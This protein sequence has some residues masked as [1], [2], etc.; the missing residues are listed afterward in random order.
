MKGFRKLQPTAQDVHAD[1]VLTNIS[2]SYAQSQDAF[3]ATKVFPIIPVDKQSDRYVVYTKNDWFRDEARKR[4]DNQESAGSGYNLSRDSYQA[5]VWAIHKDVGR[6]SRLNADSGIDLDDGATRF[7]TN[8]ILLRQEI[9]FV[10]D[11][12]TTGVWGT[13]ATPAATWDDYTGSDPIEDIE[14]AKESILSVTG[15]MP[16]TLVI[17]YQAFRKLKHHPDLVARIQFS[18]DKVL[19]PQLVARFLELDNVYV[20]RAIKA[21]NV[22]GETAAYAFVHGKHAWVG[23]VNPSP[24]PFE[25][26]AGYTFSWNGFNALGSAIA[27]DKFEI[28]RTKTTRYEAESAWD[29][30]VIGTDLGYFMPNVVP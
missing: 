28:L 13:D 8:R 19:T 23:Y 20:A 9:Q 4:G 11:F 3:I 15:Q 18:S 21:T 26:S 2:I 27:V 1:A 24:G 22:E 17:G 16:N 5:D 7:V 14:V 12:F 6:Q 30:K 10:T 25:A 29:N